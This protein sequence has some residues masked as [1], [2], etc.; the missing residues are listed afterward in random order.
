MLL[1]MIV[2]DDSL[3]TPVW[4]PMLLQTVISYSDCNL[5]RPD[6]NCVKLSCGSVLSGFSF[7]IFCFSYAIYSFSSFS[8]KVLEL[9]PVLG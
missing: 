8:E 6:L 4:F 3:F 2:L 9:L 1:N 5:S 7:S